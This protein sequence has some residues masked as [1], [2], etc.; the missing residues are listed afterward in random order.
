MQSET[1]W[2]T[3]GSGKEEAERK[4][5]SQRMENSKKTRPSNAVILNLRVTL[6]LG[7]NGVFTGVT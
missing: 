5:E 2:S 1:L 7:S 6:S 4:Q 3:Q